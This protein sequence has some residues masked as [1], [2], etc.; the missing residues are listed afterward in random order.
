MQITDNELLAAQ[1]DIQM[2]QVNNNRGKS[3]AMME[4]EALQGQLASLNSDLQ[5]MYAHRTL[6]NEAGRAIPQGLIIQT[7]DAEKAVADKKREMEGV[8]KTVHA[9]LAELKTIRAEQD[10]QTAKQRDSYITQ[11]KKTARKFAQQADAAIQALEAAIV[12]LHGAL[13]NLQR[14]GAARTGFTSNASYFTRN[15]IGKR[16]LGR[17]LELRSTWTYSGASISTQLEGMLKNG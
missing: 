8:A 14:N 3:A 2:V 16:Q 17:D 10:K 11:N 9:E 7:A 15:A 4:L 12:G 6:L 13:T 1:S 5:R